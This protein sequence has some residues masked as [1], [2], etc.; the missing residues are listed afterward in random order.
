VWPSSN[1]RN[2]DI[3]LL[4]NYSNGLVFGYAGIGKNGTAVVS[5]SLLTTTFNISD[6]SQSRYSYNQTNTS[7]PVVAI[8][9]SGSEADMNTSHII[10]VTETRLPTFGISNTISHSFI[11]S[12]IIPGAEYELQSTR[13]IASTNKLSE[14]TLILHITPSKVV[15]MADDT[16]ALTVLPLT[17][18]SIENPL[19]II[20]IT[21]SIPMLYSPP[22]S[23][24]DI[25]YSSSSSSAAVSTSISMGLNVMNTDFNLPDYI[26]ACEKF[27][28]ATVRFVFGFSLFPIVILVIFTFQINSDSELKSILNAEVRL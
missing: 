19:H 13:N 18:S 16:K 17:S 4:C 11:S 24:A 9:P 23:I 6:L 27:I 21:S 20:E 7:D 10:L 26:A 1:I 2:A 14:T 22:P 15:S 12:K 5:R 28:E 25:S 3:G 8:F